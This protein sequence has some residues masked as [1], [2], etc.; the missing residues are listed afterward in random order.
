MRKRKALTLTMSVK[1]DRSLKHTHL[2][3][4][5]TVVSTTVDDVLVACGGVSAQG[6]VAEGIDV[7]ALRLIFLRT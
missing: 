5:S 1:G 2:F 6:W 7:C 3:N 4:R